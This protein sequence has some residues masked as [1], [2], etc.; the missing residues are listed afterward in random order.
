MFMDPITVEE[1]MAVLEAEAVAH[2]GVVTEGEPYVSPMS[3]VV[4]GDRIYFRTMVGRRLEAIRANPV[5]SIEVSRYDRAT[6]DWV[7]VIVKGTATETDDYE[8][9][10]MVVGKLMSK[11]REVVGSPLSRGG[12][13]PLAGLP[14]VVEVAIDEISGMASGRGWRPATRPGHL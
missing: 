6:G 7:S 2:I 3:F 10:N 8:T 11:Y 14:H 5:V 9:R 4:N 13:H 12:L 1:A